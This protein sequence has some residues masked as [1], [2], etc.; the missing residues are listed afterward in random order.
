M[1]PER[2]RRVELGAGEE[3][4]VHGDV[5]GDHLDHPPVLREPVVGLLPFDRVVQP[6]KRVPDQLVQ[7]LDHR[8]QVAGFIRLTAR[9]NER[10]APLYRILI[11]AAGTDSEATAL[12]DD[13]TRQRQQGQ[14]TIAR[15]L[16][17]SGACVLT[18]ESATPPT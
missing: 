8:M 6:G 18:S 11:S 16:A 3:H 2:W 15:A 10:I 14:R 12:L 9:V 4:H 13:L 5:E 1:I 7:A 17:R